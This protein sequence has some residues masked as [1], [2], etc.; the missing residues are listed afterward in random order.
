MSVDVSN[1]KRRGREALTKN[2]KRCPDLLEDCMNES[3]SKI[4][5]SEILFREVNF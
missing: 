3:P 2:D 1:N 5:L 4:F